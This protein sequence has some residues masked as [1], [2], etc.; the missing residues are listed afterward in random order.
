MAFSLINPN[1]NILV[2]G[3]GNFS[4]SYDVAN[5]IKEQNGNGHIFTT[6]LDSIEV[7]KEKIY[8]CCYLY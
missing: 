3:D 4:Y 5:Y 2:V 8:K 1:D 7:L 6:S